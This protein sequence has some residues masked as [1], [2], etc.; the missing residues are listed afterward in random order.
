MGAADDLPML[1]YPMDPYIPLPM[2]TGT[3]ISRV[4]MTVRGSCTVISRSSLQKIALGKMSVWRRRREDGDLLVLVRFANISMVR[5]ED[6]S[7]TTFVNILMSTV[8]CL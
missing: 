8:L 4:S 7:L 1:L 6:A 3:L 2:V 5:F